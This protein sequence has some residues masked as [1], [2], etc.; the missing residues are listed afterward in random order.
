MQ[1]CTIRKKQSQETEDVST[2][3]D[4]EVNNQKSGPKLMSPFRK[5]FK[6]GNCLFKWLKHG[7]IG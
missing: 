3:V 5:K 6:K 2:R 7:G 1:C 4:R